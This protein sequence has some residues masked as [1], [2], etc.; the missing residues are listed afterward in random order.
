MATDNDWWSRRLGEQHAP[1]PNY[2]P[3]TYPQQPQQGYPQHPQ[4]GYPQ[5]PQQGYPPQQPMVNADNLYQA[6]M[7]W[8]GGEAHRKETNRCPNCGGN[9]YFSRA[10]GV[11]RGPA[12]APLCY[13]CGFN[14]MFQQGDPATWGA[15]G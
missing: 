5:Q 11:S 9:H 3:A 10:A 8:Q 4:Q 14:G 13:D 1:P 2:P 6:A 7:T 15:T 12:P